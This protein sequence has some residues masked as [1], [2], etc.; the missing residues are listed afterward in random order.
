MH[1]VLA[2]LIF[3]I[4]VFASAFISTV[5][6]AKLNNKI[7]KIYTEE[8][9][10]YTYINKYENILKRGLGNAR[11]FVLI[12]LS[13]GYLTIENSE[14]AKQ[15]LDGIKSFPNNKRGI[16]SQVVF[17]NNLCSYYLQINDIPN[18][19]KMLENM[20]CFLQNEKFPKQRYDRTYNHYT[21][22]Q[23]SINIAKGIFNGAEEV[24]SIQFNREKTK[25]GKI[26]AKY[27]LGKIYI[28]FE[29]FEEAKEAFEYVINNGNKTYYV[30]KSID[31]LNQCKA[32]NPI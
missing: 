22:K 17:Y 24:F 29:R 20:L 21:D 13:S 9:D 2:F 14:K 15:I 31:F 1:P 18:A 27:Q 10:P 6:A 12:N 19:E 5:Y 3:I 16:E 28:H 26:F 30:G 25:L 23:Y 7:V 4:I 11:T 32:V 8:C